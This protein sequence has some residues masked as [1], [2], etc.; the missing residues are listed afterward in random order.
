MAIDKSIIETDLTKLRD[1]T[2]MEEGSG[3]L[4]RYVELIL[5]RN[6]TPIA[7]MTHRP[8]DAEKIAHLLME[9]KNKEGEKSMI[10]SVMRVQDFVPPMQAE[11]IRSLKSIQEQLPPKIFWMLPESE[12]ARVKDFL[13]T[14][15]LKP[16]GV[17]DLPPKLLDRFKEKDGSI[18]N[19]VIVEPPLND[20]IRQGE[21]LLRFVKGIREV[22]DQ[23][24]PGV[25]VAGRLPVS[26]DML[27]AVLKDGP[28]ATAVSAIAVVILTIFLF[29][30]VELSILVLSALFVGVAW[31][32]AGMHYFHLKINFLNFIALP[33]TFGIGVDYA[34][35]V[36]HRYREE[37][38]KQAHNRQ[39]AADAGVLEEKDPAGDSPII[40]AVY[41]TGGAVVLASM[42]TTIGWSSLM[43]AGNQAFVSFG[44][45]AMIGEATCVTV[46]VL[47]IPSVLIWLQ[48]RRKIE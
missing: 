38:E 5:K 2:S 19:L 20:E 17:E 33:I 3:F 29:R 37:K 8:E 34:V 21:S 44:R 30:S 32:V 14:E 23:V 41:H 25:P 27:T 24:A 9:K 15:T 35:N 31:M 7:V 40:R 36:F 28:I 42:T 11:K 10:G 6:T 18:G 46:A 47:V 43:I 1:K 4:S 22:V 12:K 45:I 39:K 48:G 13:S 16:F 26:A